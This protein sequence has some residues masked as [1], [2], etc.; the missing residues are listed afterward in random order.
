MR[1]AN[2][3]EKPRVLLPELS[4]SGSQ[5]EEG[6]ESKTTFLWKHEKLIHVAAVQTC[7][8]K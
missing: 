1:Q 2:F 6:G 3:V 5:T 4:A 7:G 8:F